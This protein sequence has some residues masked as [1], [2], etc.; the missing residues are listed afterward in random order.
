M[1]IEWHD[2]AVVDLERLKEFIQPYNIE[3]SQR[4][5]RLIRASVSH[6]KSNPRIGKPV[7]GFPHYHELVIPFGASGYVLRYRLQA[8]T[9]IIL[10]VKHSKEA[11]FSD[12]ASTLWV[13]KDPIEAAYGMLADGGTS[14]AE[15]LLE[16]RRKDNEREKSKFGL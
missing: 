16:E 14:L 4:A 7:E 15:E 10:A 1:Q 6:I 9:A 13:V 12:Q 2:S 11:G 8:N 3:A 5:I